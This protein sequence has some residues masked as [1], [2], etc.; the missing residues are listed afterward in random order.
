MV[1]YRSPLSI[2]LHPAHSIFFYSPRNLNECLAVSLG[3]CE[4]HERHGTHLITYN[5]NTSSL[6]SGVSG[7][8]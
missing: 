2:F 5:G 4:H 1:I 8:L 3:I 6:V 7:F